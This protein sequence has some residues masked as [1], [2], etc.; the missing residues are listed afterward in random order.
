MKKYG[1]RGRIK[2]RE[3]RIADDLG[4]KNER[5]QLTRLNGDTSEKPLLQKSSLKME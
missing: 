2:P 1:R 3:K 5:V 4:K